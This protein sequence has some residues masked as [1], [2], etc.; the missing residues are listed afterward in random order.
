MVVQPV[1]INDNLTMFIFSQSS[2]FFLGTKGSQK[3]LFRKECLVMAVE[4]D[5]KTFMQNKWPI[6][7]IYC[8][9]RINQL[10]IKP[11]ALMQN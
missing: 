4:L 1:I 7:K 2:W 5:K 3:K 11:T 10:K 6:K 9:I 8:S